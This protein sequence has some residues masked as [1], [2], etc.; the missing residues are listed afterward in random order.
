M[1]V[2]TIALININYPSIVPTRALL[3]NLF[4]KIMYAAQIIITVRVYMHVVLQR[5][6]MVLCVYIELQIKFCLRLTVI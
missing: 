2:R 4:I 6:L 3:Y 1:Y 5:K